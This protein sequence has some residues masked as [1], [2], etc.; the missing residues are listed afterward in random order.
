L[1]AHA[2]LEDALTCQLR[3]QL[4][5]GALVLLVD[6]RVVVVPVGVPELGEIAVVELAEGLID[7]LLA[8]LNAGDARRLVILGLLRRRRCRW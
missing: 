5:L 8:L 2:G 6:L 7:C 4:V 1:V 3:L